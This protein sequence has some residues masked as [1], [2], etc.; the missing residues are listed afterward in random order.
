[1]LY[2]GNRVIA[3]DYLYGGT[4]RLF[5]RV[6]RRSAGLEFS[7]VDMTTTGAVEAALRANTR[8]L[9]VE[10]PSNPMFKLAD[11]SALAAIARRRDL[12]SV[13]DNTF[14]TRVNPRPLE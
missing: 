3:G 4:F 5:E 11:L 12:L 1:P 14:A 7:F 2:A 13:A 8:M 6:R 9:W 10:T